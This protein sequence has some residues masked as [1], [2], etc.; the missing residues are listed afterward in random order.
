MLKLAK[1][2]NEW[3]LAPDG[4]ISSEQHL[5]CMC[6]VVGVKSDS[7]NPNRC[8]VRLTNGNLVPLMVK[9]DDF[10]NFLLNH[11]HCCKKH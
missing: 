10:V 3:F 7:T 11:K 8:L 1:N 9:F 2:S 5:M 4:D 6:S